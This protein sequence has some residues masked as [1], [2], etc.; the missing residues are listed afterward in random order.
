MNRNIFYKKFYAMLRELGIERH[1]ESLLAGYGVDSAK[2]LKD[3]ELSELVDRVEKM[4]YHKT[5]VSPRTRAM[6]SECLCLLQKLGI[7]ADNN[8]WHKVNEYLKDPRIAGKELFRMSDNELFDL[9]RK[10]NAILP[11]YKAE[12]KET[13][14]L[15]LNN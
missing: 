3:D 5:E 2:D 10:L 6:R 4:K 1:K 15:T 11:K 12:I 8:D 7:Y 13:E 14:R 9:K